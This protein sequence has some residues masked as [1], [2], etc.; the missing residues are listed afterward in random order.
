[1]CLAELSVP[2]TGWSA[3]MA[4]PFS[5]KTLR[6]KSRAKRNSKAAAILKYVRLKTGNK[7]G[8]SLS[9]RTGSLDKKLKKNEMAN[10]VWGNLLCSQGKK[11]MQGEISDPNLK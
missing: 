6:I 1:M 11:I 3:F 8:P 9:R 2:L 5:K 10:I 4:N 7:L